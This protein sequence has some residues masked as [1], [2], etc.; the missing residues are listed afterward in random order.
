[1]KTHNFYPIN[2]TIIISS[3]I[4]SDLVKKFIFFKFNLVNFTLNF[5]WFNKNID[6]SVFVIESK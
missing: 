3:L 6:G 2:I 5:P 4:S 1:M